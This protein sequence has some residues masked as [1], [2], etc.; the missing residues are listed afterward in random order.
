MQTK[1]IYYL[2]R[3]LG[4]LPLRLLHGLGHAIGWLL[5]KIPNREL[6]TARVNLALCFPGLSEDER[7]KM[8]GRVLRENVITLLEMPAV[9]FGDTRRWL[10]RLDME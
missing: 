7:E 10:Q 1:L 3:I 2:I 4:A 8:L 6:R 5:Y 9:W